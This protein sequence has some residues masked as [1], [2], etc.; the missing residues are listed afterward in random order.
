MNG[1]V[2][3]MILYVLTGCPPP[4]E[5]HDASVLG[6]CGKIEKILKKL[7]TLPCFNFCLYKS[8]YEKTKKDRKWGKDE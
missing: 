6:L 3:M 4:Q 1:G 7:R 8:T 2:V 5:L